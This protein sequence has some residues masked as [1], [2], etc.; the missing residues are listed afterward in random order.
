VIELERGNFI[1][2]WRVIYYLEF[3]SYKIQSKMVGIHRKR[4]SPSIPFLSLMMENLKPWG[5]Y[6][7]KF[8]FGQGKR[9]REDE[10]YLILQLMGIPEMV[11][12]VSFAKNQKFQRGWVGGVGVRKRGRIE[13]WV[14]FTDT[15]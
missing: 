4:G 11:L 5:G 2:S 7:E 14:L 3:L 13:R 9:I 6:K 12:H 10:V 15:K 8:C 1:S